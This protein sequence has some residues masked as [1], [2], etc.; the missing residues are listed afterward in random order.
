MALAVLAILLGVGVPSFQALFERN[1]VS[2]Q[3]NE[4]L[5]GLQMARSEAIRRNNPVRFCSS[6]TGWIVRTPASVEPI[7]EGGIQQGTSVTEACID[8]RSDGLPY[9]CT[10]SS[11]T[12]GANLVTAGTISVTTGDQTRNIRI[13]TGSIHVSQN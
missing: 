10:C 12:L 11:N 13:R 4:V 5:S 2:S 9:S 7:R 8:F 6:D 3:T 1:R